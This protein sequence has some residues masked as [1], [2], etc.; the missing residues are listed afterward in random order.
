MFDFVERRV[1]NIELTLVPSLQ[2][3][4]RKC[5]AENMCDIIFEKAKGVY[6]EA[7]VQRVL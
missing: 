7:T 5:S 1:W 3:K 6:A 4:P 2:I